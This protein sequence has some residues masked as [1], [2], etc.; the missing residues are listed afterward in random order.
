[1]QH[2]QPNTTLQGGKY[3]I[4]R[5]LGQ[6]GFGNTKITGTVP[7]STHLQWQASHFEEACHCFLISSYE[8]KLVTILV[9]QKSGG[10]WLQN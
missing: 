1:M 3:R 5:V 8:P 7:R 4:E 6:G 10:G 2:L 9:R